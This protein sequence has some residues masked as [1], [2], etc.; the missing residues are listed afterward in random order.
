L[1]HTHFGEM[2]ERIPIFA[3]SALLGLLAGAALAGRLTA[4]R[5]RLSLRDLMAAVAF[6]ALV[7]GLV[8][9]KPGAGRVTAELCAV[10]ALVMGVLDLCASRLLEPWRR[11]PVY[12]ERASRRLRRWLP[13]AFV[14]TTAGLVAFSKL[15]MDIPINP[16]LLPAFAVRVAAGLVCLT[17][18][19]VALRLA[20]A[21]AGRL[22]RGGRRSHEPGAA[23]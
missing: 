10:G 18:L 11:T 21:G 13:V 2:Y 6:A 3:A 5:A 12:S 14:L 22:F 1:Y 19:D 17:A 20:A 7:S 15:R 4:G 23:R 9:A 16:D 8:A